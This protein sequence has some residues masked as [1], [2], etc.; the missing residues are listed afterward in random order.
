MGWLHLLEGDWATAHARLEHEIA[1]ARAGNLMLV[2]PIA[3]AASAWALAHLGEAGEA[4]GRLLEGEEL[5]ERYAAEGHVSNVAWV[6]HAL[7]RAC[8]LLGRLDEAQRLGARALA[9]SPHHP[10]FAAHA[11]HLL[12]DVATHPDRFD[13]ERA[14]AQY[15]QALALAEPCGMRPLVAHCHLGLGRLYARIGRREEAHAELS[16]AIALYRAMDMT[17]W[18]AEAEAPL[19]QVKE[20]PG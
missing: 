10:G 20:R 4:T 5:L 9:S 6:C 12:G 16:A 7:G 14:E 13:A 18:L 17:F 3:V 8:L 2:L 1:V 11:R 15:R 19:A